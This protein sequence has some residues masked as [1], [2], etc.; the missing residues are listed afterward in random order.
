MTDREI[1][2]DYIKQIKTNLIEIE[3]TRIE[4]KKLIETN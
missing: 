2:E 4:I 3:K 1:V